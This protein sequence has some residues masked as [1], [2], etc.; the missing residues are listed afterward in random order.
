MNKNLSAQL[1]GLTLLV[2][3]PE[4]AHAQLQVKENFNGTGLSD[5]SKTWI[6]LN[7]A[8]LTASTSHTV[9]TPSNPTPGVI[10][11]CVS[12]GTTFALSNGNSYYTS[13]SS[14]LVGG[15]SGGPLP[16]ASGNGVLR[17]TNGASSTSPMTST[18]GNNETGAFILANPFPSNSGMNISR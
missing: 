6:A 4:F 10:P 12:G 15:Q 8:C 3:L 18:N 2:L 16:D 1:L 14:I 7:G 9:F 11:G 13:K 5:T 17:L